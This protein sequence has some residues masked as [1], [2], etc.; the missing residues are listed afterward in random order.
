M[1]Y[2]LPG[3]GQSL[4]LVLLFLL[5]S[6]ASSVLT[7][8]NIESLSVSYAASMIFPLAWGWIVSRQNG[9]RGMCGYVNVEDFQKGTFRCGAVPVLLAMC[10]VPCASMLLEP[11]TSLIPMSDMLREIFEKMFDKSRPVDLIISTVVLAPLCEE[12]LCR[13]LICRGMLAR[14]KPAVAILWSAF[15]FALMH[16]NFSQ[17]AVAFGLGILLGWV[18]WKTHS[19]WCTIAM[20]FTNNALS[21]AMMF[22]FP[23][24]PFDA[25]YADVMPQNIYIFVLIAAVVILAA[26]VHLL[27][28]RIKN[29][30][31]ISFEIRGSACGEEMGW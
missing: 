22:L 31:A 19:L 28:S 18:Y 11:V 21:V 9:R 3:W 30:E 7:A 6:V 5:G 20:H 29:E 24:L 1:K 10:M 8:T 2:Y 12:M 26:S 23:D 25:T 15:I 17:G 14:H 4:L 13:G 16:G 27:N